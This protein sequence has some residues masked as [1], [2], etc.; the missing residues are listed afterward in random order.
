MPAL[1]GHDMMLLA[2]AISVPCWPCEQTGFAATS[3]LPSLVRVPFVGCKADGQAGPIEAPHGEPKALEIEDAASRKLAYY[4]AFG[5][6]VLAPRGWYCFG[7]YGSGGDGLFVSPQ[8]ID[9]TKL[10]S[11]NTNVFPGPGLHVSRAFGDTS[12]RFT[13]AQVAARV[14]PAHRRYAREV[15]EGFDLSLTFAPFP[16]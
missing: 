9:D 1:R 12:G 15:A 13:V 14:F 4:E 2:L 16:N 3:G 10:F 8:P 11:Q 5:L 7:V 6:G